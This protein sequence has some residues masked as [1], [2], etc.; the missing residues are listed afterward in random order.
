VVPGVRDLFSGCY[1]IRL[2]TLK[3]SVQD[4]QALLQTEGWCANAELVA[5]AAA[6][7]RQI[8]TV[9]VAP[10]RAAGPA[11]YPGAARLALGLFKA[12]RT[13]RIPA[14]EVVVERTA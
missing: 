14:P 7:A 2:A 5:R 8:A 12:G 13:L 6:N 11:A 9:P 3:R 10:G 4:Q 1:A